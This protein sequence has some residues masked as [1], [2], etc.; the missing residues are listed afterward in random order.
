MATFR[1]ERTIYRLEGINWPRPKRQRLGYRVLSS[2]GK[3]ERTTN[4]PLAA[5]GPCLRMGI[6]RASS[7][8]PGAARCFGIRLAT[9]PGSVAARRFANLTA[10]TE[11][12]GRIAT[13]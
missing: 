11:G 2:F 5:L 7:R 3:K 13:S 8:R 12:A 6:Q 9:V 1:L 10:V 4:P